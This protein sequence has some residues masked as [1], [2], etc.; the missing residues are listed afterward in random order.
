MSDLTLLGRP[1]GEL[2]HTREHERGAM[3]QL[4]VT[5][6]TAMI[7][8]VIAAAISV[9]AALTNSNY[10][11]I[12]GNV[13]VKSMTLQRERLPRY[14][15]YLPA[16]LL[17]MRLLE[18][19]GASRLLL[20]ASSAALVLARILHGIGVARLAP[21]FCNVAGAIGATTLVVLCASYGMV[22]EG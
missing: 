2:E 10:E 21:Q 4:P 3:L 15:E 8:V 14:V 18:T 17:L 19:A 9:R 11:A 5:L 6:T 1:W 22:I 20:G 12:L 16:L 13:E 7:L